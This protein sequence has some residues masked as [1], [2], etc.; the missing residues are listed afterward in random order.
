MYLAIT[1]DDEYNEIL[2]NSKSPRRTVAS[3]RQHRRR[4]KAK[5]L[6]EQHHGFETALNSRYTNPRRKLR[7]F[8]RH[9]VPLV[10]I[11]T[12]RAVATHSGGG[13]QPSPTILEED[14][15]DDI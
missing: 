12:G 11:S 1:K 2:A 5:E 3:F 8:D 13:L 7:L 15:S 14:E 10:P 6:E 9:G 4:R